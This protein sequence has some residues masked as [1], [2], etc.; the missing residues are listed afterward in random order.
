MKDHEKENSEDCDSDFFQ[1]PMKNLDDFDHVSSNNRDSTD[2]F[3]SA[4]NE[5]NEKTPVPRKSDY[6]LR[7]TILRKACS[8]GKKPLK[9]SR[10]SVHFGVRKGRKSMSVKKGNKT[11]LASLENA[12]NVS[13]DDASKRQTYDLSGIMHA[14]DEVNTTLDKVVVTEETIDANASDTQSKQDVGK[15]NDDQIDVNN[16]MSED[17]DFRSADVVVENVPQS[18]ENETTSNRSSYV[19]SSPVIAKAVRFSS[20]EKTKISD[21]SNKTS[22]EIDVT[23]KTVNNTASKIRDRKATPAVNGMN[24]PPRFKNYIKRLSKTPI[25]ENEDSDKDDTTCKKSKNAS[26]AEKKIVRFDV[27]KSEI[28]NVVNKKTSM[29]IKKITIGVSKPITSSSKPKTFVYRNSIRPP[30]KNATPKEQKPAVKRS[31]YHSMAE[32]QS[33]V[34]LR[35]FSPNKPQLVRTPAKPK[36]TLTKPRGPTLLTEQRAKQHLLGRKN[37]LPAISEN[38]KTNV[39]GDTIDKAKQPTLPIS[40]FAKPGVIPPKRSSATRG[41]TNLNQP[42]IHRPLTK[43]TAPVFRTEMRLAQWN[44]KLKKTEEK[45]TCGDDTTAV[46]TFTFRARPAP[47]F[48]RVVASG[49]LA[50]S[51]TVKRSPI[52]M[53]PFSFEQREKEKKE[54]AKSATITSETSK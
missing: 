22:G 36:P 27:K 8:S 48:K 37:L 40:R 10:S 19:V 33:T 54:K 12:M 43:A 6:F 14:L 3:F 47:N 18:N 31:S 39:C 32:M 38:N 4:A 13:D 35:H 53:K 23:P 9:E 30:T 7:Q 25:S 16:L 46:N 20:S 42:K 26:V 24:I 17:E 1:T 49:K 41:P 45:N 28:N 11:A 5:E 34:L 15:A 44:Q 51:G 52:K 29:P 2:E 21:S 50:S